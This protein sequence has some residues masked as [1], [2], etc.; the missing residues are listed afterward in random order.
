MKNVVCILRMKKVGIKEAGDN[1]E[2]RNCPYGK[3]DFDRRMAWYSKII[4]ERGTEMS[5]Y[6]KVEDVMALINTPNR[7]NCDYF[8]VD[9]I[10]QLCQSDKVFDLGTAMAELEIKKDEARILA[11]MRATKVYGD[12]YED[13][14]FYSGQKTAYSSAIETIEKHTAG[15]KQ[16]ILQQQDEDKEKEIEVEF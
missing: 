14:E 13:D 8:I 1:L 9:Q 15:V 3:E 12:E 10:E 5:K 11:G 2:C 6:V 7:G 4:K 16:V